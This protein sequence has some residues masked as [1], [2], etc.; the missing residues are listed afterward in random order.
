MTASL[1]ATPCSLKSMDKHITLIV[2]KILLLTPLP[3][4]YMNQSKDGRVSS[5]E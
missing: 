3:E 2:S 1:T 4:Y 5:N